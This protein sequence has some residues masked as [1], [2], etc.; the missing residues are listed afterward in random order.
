MNLVLSTT[1][2]RASPRVSANSQLLE[3]EFNSLSFLVT[4]H[5]FLSIKINIQI[6]VFTLE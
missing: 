4:A 3:S 5:K 2:P 6:S 1:S